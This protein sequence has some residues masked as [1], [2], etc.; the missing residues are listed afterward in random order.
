M[1]ASW[2]RICSV[3]ER[4]IGAGPVLSRFYVESPRTA[5]PP[6][7][8]AKTCCR[9]MRAHGTAL[10]TVTVQSTGTLG[11]SPEEKKRRHDTSKE[12]SQKLCLLGFAMV[13]ERMVCFFE[14]LRRISA[15]STPT[16]KPSQDL[17]PGDAG[18][19]YSIVYSNSTKYRYIGVVAWRKETEARYVK[20]DF[21][22]TLPSGVCYGKRENGMFFNPF[23]T[24]PTNL[25][26]NVKYVCTLIINKNVFFYFGT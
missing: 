25:T 13:K 2:Y 16:K 20:R 9:A 21:T 23:R 11:L 24:A 4:W 17:L 10:S 5:H 26:R 14:V 19:W 18:T 3:P 7:S 6:R 15:D 22:K 12:I 1:S 8:R